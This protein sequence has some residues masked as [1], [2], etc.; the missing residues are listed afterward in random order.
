MRRWWHFFHQLGIQTWCS[1][2]Q[3]CIELLIVYG[4]ALGRVGCERLHF[5]LFHQ[6]LLHVCQG[7]TKP[8]DVEQAQENNR[9]QNST[10]GM[11]IN[12]QSYARSCH[13]KASARS[14]QPASLILR[15]CQYYLHFFTCSR[16]SPWIWLLFLHLPPVCRQSSFI[17]NSIYSS[18]SIYQVDCAKCLDVFYQI[19]L[20]QQLSE[21]GLFLSHFT[22]MEMRIGEVAPNR[23][24]RKWKSW[25]LDPAFS[26]TKLLI[27]SCAALIII[28][29]YLWGILKFTKHSHKA[30]H[31]I[32]QIEQRTR[33]DRSYAIF[34]DMSL[35]DLLK[36]TCAWALASD[37]L[38]FLTIP[39]NI[40]LFP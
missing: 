39:I 9:C 17:N 25:H 30:C 35:S 22:A 31:L 7:G 24:A 11:Y 21:V 19:W 20:L 36:A 8:L 14:S 4:M 28:I 26:V 3:Q 1:I 37:L 23:T 29:F 15:P 27:P 38:T 2:W 16:P 40:M 6:L 13:C 10:C 34:T 12:I 5:L 32:L 33:Q 18:F